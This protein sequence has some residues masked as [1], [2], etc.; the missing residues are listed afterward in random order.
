M[1]SAEKRIRNIGNTVTSSNISTGFELSKT[2][3]KH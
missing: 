1:E 2:E 3:E